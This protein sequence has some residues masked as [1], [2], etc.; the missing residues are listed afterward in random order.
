MENEKIVLRPSSIRSFLETPSKWWKN[1]VLGEDKFETQASAKGMS[2]K[3][4]VQYLADK[5]K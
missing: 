5:D 1:H 3:D 2:I 4:Y